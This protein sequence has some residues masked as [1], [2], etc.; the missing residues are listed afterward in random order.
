MEERLVQLSAPLY[1]PERS[2]LGLTGFNK[3][4]M[5]LKEMVRKAGVAYSHDGIVRNVVDQ[6]AENF[7]DFSFKSDN[8][9]AIKY[10]EKRLDL[11]GLLTGEYWK[12]TF[13]R[14][15]H[16]YF[17]VGNCFSIKVRGEELSA[18]RVMYAEKPHPIVAVQLISASRL[19]SKM[20]K[21]RLALG[22]KL[23]D[24]DPKSTT[25]LKKQTIMRGAKPM[26]KEQAK[27]SRV[28][29][30]KDENLLIPGIDILHLAYTK[31]ADCG[32]GNGMTFS[33][34]EDIS[35]LR[36][37]ESN[38]SV[39]IK[40]YSMPLI[41]HI[42]GRVAGPAMGF[43]TDIDRA[44][45]MHQQ[46][47]PEGVIV[48]GANHEIKA[49]GAESQALRVEGYLDFFAARASVGIGGSPELL[50]LT[51][52]SSAQSSTAA[53]ERMMRKVRACQSAISWE[54]QY[55]L[56]WEILWEGGFDPYEKE[57][58]RVYIEF[59]DIDEDRM[60]KLQTHA[61]DAHTKGLI[62]HDQAMDISKGN[63]HQAFKRKP[64]EQKMFV[65]RSQIPLKKAGPPKTAP[66]KKK[67]SKPRARASFESLVSS[68]AAFDSMM[69]GWWPKN[70]ADVQEFLWALGA[71][72]SVD[73]RVLEELEEPIGLLLED[74]QAL[75]DFLHQ[76]LN[77]EV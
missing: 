33:G 60:I 40:K 23:E 24:S 32:L 7:K 28:M 20:S 70:E 59:V 39:M 53:V 31:E 43:Q 5:S 9:Q 45:V 50:G 19:E 52:K 38:T 74:K 34:L 57:E 66:A 1:S 3:R 26:N 36:A 69:E 54:L 30:S 58:D 4:N 67:T 14:M 41:H 17:K 51:G 22:W 49:V 42:I 15:I 56:L 77:L 71:L 48:T 11:M 65:N 47:A 21:D 12:I 29:G 76:R 75:K 37:I 61:A 2:T 35:L 27:V 44:V 8:E 6:H 73:E 55:G 25:S 62:D 18:K 13:K 63:M 16:E 46:S 72:Y 64:S 10:L 68:R